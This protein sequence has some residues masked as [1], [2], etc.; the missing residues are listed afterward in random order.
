[1]IRNKRKQKQLK[2]KFFNRRLS[3]TFAIFSLANISPYSGPSTP[4]N[5]RLNSTL[6]SENIFQWLTW[7]H[8]KSPEISSRVSRGNRRL[9]LKIDTWR[10]S[11][12][13]PPANKSAEN[14]DADD[15]KID[16]QES[17]TTNGKS[18]LEES[19]LKVIKKIGS[20]S[21]SKVKVTS[22]LSTLRFSRT[23]NWVYARTEKHP[24]TCLR[25]H[26]NVTFPRSWR[27]PRAISR[28]SPS[29]SCRSTTFQTSSFASSFTAKSWWRSFSSMKT[30][31]NTTTAWNRRTGE[32]FCHI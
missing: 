6:W 5:S 8:P 21:Y 7:Q 15:T 30:S 31:S 12:P 3:G 2:R 22:P 32:R 26:P 1:M 27:S 17:I 19:G 11:S 10:L 9:R 28:W 20:G 13:F 23:A 18:L 25:I 14:S 24:T 29:K 4:L 16:A